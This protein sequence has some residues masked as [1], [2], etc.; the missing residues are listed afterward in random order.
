MSI[1]ISIPNFS[2]E[3]TA[4][5]VREEGSLRIP[6]L[7]GNAIYD[8]G[9]QKPFPLSVAFDA[10]LALFSK[11]DKV[12][13]RDLKT[14]SVVSVIFG[15]GSKVTRA[16]FSPDAKQILVGY[17]D[18]TAKL[19]Q[20]DDG[21]SL[22]ELDGHEDS[23][24]GLVISPDGKMA[25]SS[26]LSSSGIICYWN[27]S[28]G[29]LIST[30]TYN[31]GGLGFFALAFSPDGTKALAGGFGNAHISEDDET[32]MPGVIYF[33]LDTDTYISSFRHLGIV[34]CVAFSSD[35]KLGISGDCSYGTIRLWDL[36]AFSHLFTL[37]NHENIVSLAFS[38][39]GKYVF[40]A[41]I[42]S[43]KQWKLVYEE[44]DFNDPSTIQPWHLLSQRQISTEPVP[45]TGL[46]KFY[47]GTTILNVCKMNDAC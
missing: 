44:K 28:E 6:R 8:Q 35:G 30:P 38:S 21:T 10:K 14:L 40:S 24:S 5:S 7:F 3:E 36:E 11:D 46:A 23:I 19:C 31:G 34:N 26:D 20:S 9:I 1:S 42:S 37:K 13:V 27:L 2:P 16:T 39:S 15:H 43:I 32:L 18:G 33:E 25:L 29:T 45:E 22:F 4:L 12:E 17:G 47:W 41:S